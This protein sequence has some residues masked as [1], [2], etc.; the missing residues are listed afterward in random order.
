MITIIPLATYI[1]ETQISTKDL[2]WKM[3]KYSTLRLFHEKK[4]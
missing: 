3:L 4:Q 1:S 2:F